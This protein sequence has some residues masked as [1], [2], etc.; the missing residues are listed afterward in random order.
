M[1]AYSEKLYWYEK[2]KPSKLAFGNDPT[3][4]FFHSKG[5]PCWNEGI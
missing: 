5:P 4:E 2:G 3:K 1:K